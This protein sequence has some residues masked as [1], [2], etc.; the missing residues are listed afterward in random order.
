MVA[1]PDAVHVDTTGLT[2]AE[3][4]QQVVGLARERAGRP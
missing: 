3:V 2:I 4:V 1:A